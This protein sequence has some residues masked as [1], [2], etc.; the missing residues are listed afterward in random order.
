MIAGGAD[1]QHAAHGGVA[2]DVGV[3]S[4]H[5]ADAGVDVGDLIDGLHQHGVGFSGAGT[6]GSVEDVGLGRGVE[7]VVHELTLHG[8][9]NGFDVGRLVNKLAFQFALDVIGYPGCVSGV[10]VT[11]DL[12]GAQDRAG[13][14]ILFIENH[15]TV[16]FDD[17]LD[18]GGDPAFYV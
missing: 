11:G 17:T 10:S 2:V 12:Q 4:L 16:A 9:L 15:A 6:G 18:H 13:N 8:V 3:V 1:L 5:V 7:A 14:F